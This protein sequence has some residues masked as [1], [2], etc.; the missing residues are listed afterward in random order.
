MLEIINLEVFGAFGAVLA[1]LIW[2]LV[3]FKKEAEEKERQLTKIQNER[4]QDQD[5]QLEA[6]EATNEIL[7]EMLS[8]EEGRD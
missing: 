8:N 6:L 2:A 4:L 5:K 7:R 3:Y 1:A